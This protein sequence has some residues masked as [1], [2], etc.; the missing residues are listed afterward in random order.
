MGKKS[1]DKKALGTNGLTKKQ[2]P[3]T[4]IIHGKN[5]ISLYF[6]YKKKFQKSP[7]LDGSLRDYYKVGLFAL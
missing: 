5:H 6:G 2:E 7:C 1:D 3:G 4:G